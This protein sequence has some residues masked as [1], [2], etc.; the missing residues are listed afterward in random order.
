MTEQEKKEELYV[1][2]APQPRKL[3]LDQVKANGL[4]L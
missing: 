1:P 2:Q 4:Y 3:A